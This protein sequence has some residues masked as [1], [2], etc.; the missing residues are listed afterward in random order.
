M[1][2]E[3]FD[4]QKL[5]ICRRE[6]EKDA[7]M[8]GCTPQ[9]NLYGQKRDDV[10]QALQ[11]AAVRE[12]EV[13][14]A[15][16]HGHKEQLSQ[17]IPSESGEVHLFDLCLT[18]GMDNTAFALAE[19]GVPGCV[20]EAHHLDL[21]SYLPSTLPTFWPPLPSKPPAVKALPLALG[22]YRGCDCW[23]QETCH[24]CTWGFPVDQGIWMTDW[25]LRLLDARSAAIKAMRKPL[26][27]RVM[28]AIMSDIDL[29]FQVSQ[30]CAAR[31]LDIAI[32]S[33]NKEAAAALARKNPVRPLRRWS[34]SDMFGTLCPSWGVQLTHYNTQ[35]AVLLA[36]LH[37]GARFEDIL[38]R[39]DEIEGS[40]NNLHA[41]PL[42]LTAAPVPLRESLFAL[43]W[44]IEA[45]AD[46]LPNSKSPW[47]PGLPNDSGRCL[48]IRPWVVS[49]DRLHKARVHGID[50]KD[51]LVVKSSPYAIADDPSH[52]VLDL[53]IIKGL[54]DCA[55][56][57]AEM[58]MRVRDVELCRE[59]TV[60]EVWGRRLFEFGL[61]ASAA[62][63]F[64]ATQENCL[65]AATAAGRAALKASWRRES[66]KG[67]AMYQ[68]FLKL[69][70]GRSFPTWLIQQILFFST[71][72]PEII[73]QLS[74][75]D[76]V[77]GWQDGLVKPPPAATGATSNEAHAKSAAA[78]EL[79]ETAGATSE[80]SAPEASPA[81]AAAVDEV[82]TEELDDLMR[83]V[84]RS[85]EDVRA[86]NRYG[87]SLFKL[88]R[89]ATS[90]FMN[91]LLF[92]PQGPL[93]VLHDR[94][95]AA[96]CQVAPAWSPVKALFIPMTEEQMQ[97]LTDLA[98]H[99]YE[100]NKED[101]ILALK[102]DETLLNEALKS[103]SRA[104]NRP[105]AKQVGPQIQQV[106]QSSTD[107]PREADSDDGMDEDDGP[108]VV[109][110]GAI[111]TDSSVG[112]PAP[113]P[114]SSL[115]P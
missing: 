30:K 38:L 8:A 75:W 51:W 103:R 13:A 12:F 95:L 48:C 21:G 50:V 68:L 17:K 73:E 18:F 97:E 16:L 39:W 114:I 23:E 90:A 22:R 83:A 45:F 28:G 96:E 3:S 56:A 81:V 92:D 40:C 87:V 89:M 106:P 79:P 57:C 53:S 102:E 108:M 49:L 15:L 58:G 104:K 43:G 5:V 46:L 86:F 71:K 44:P 101:H 113:Y 42:P 14:K 64:I 91:K 99:G 29:P 6:V 85:K 76:D 93:K 84:Q 62:D 60:G 109:L 66:A 112:F 98:A 82:K 1:E 19:A 36:A 54:T 69:A 35:A 78:T 41:A 20:L 4:I 47:T 34:I 63:G 32:L 72:M 26:V 55:A 100:L 77:A 80:V 88:T 25:N 27:L 110:E 52:S 111:S 61:T 2:V 10:T 94:V 107:V 74:L 70:K 59:A 33:G 11:I 67:V 37:A 9:H 31:L 65:C 7:A 115:W 105:K 24:Y